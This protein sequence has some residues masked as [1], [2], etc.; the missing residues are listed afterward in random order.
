MQRHNRVGQ[1]G[2]WERLTAAGVQTSG[3]GDYAAAVQQFQAALPL[4]D[5]GSLVPSLMNLAGGKSGADW[6]FLSPY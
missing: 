6:D 4:A 3:Q 1:E 2:H 5:V